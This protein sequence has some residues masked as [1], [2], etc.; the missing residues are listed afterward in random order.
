MRTNLK[1]LRNRRKMSVKNISLMLDISA[2]HYYKIESG[3]RNPNFVL[4]GKI[5]TLLD[6]SVDELFFK[7][8]LDKMSKIN[9]S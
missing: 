7:D 2:S 6:C 5:A 8:E 9:A 3:I 4:A 1:T